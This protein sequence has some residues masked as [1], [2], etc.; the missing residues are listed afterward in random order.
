MSGTGD[1]DDGENE[2]YDKTYILQQN[3]DS[4]GSICLTVHLFT[5]D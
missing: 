5:L 1:L 4:H 3:N 2:S